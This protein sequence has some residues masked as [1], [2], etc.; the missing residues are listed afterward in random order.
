MYESYPAP[1]AAFFVV[2]FDGQVL[3]CGGMAQL[4]GGKPGVCELKKMYFRPELRGL[5]AGT[6]LM[7]LILDAAR[8]AGYRT[9]YL[10]TLEHMSQARA[11]YAKHGFKAIDG[12]LGK[13]GH[14]SCNHF[15]VL[16]LA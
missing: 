16:D 10:E 4:A 13:T 1:G 9:C 7:K 15:M 14:T 2:E 11:L 3:G 6:R 5:G 8:R 12:P